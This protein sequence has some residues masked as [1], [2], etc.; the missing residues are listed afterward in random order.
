MST[1]TLTSLAILKV[2]L[3]EGRDYL[4]YLRPF[5]LQVLVDHKPA[6]ITDRVVTSYI[7]KQFGLDIPERAVEIV[8][9]RISKSGLLKKEHGKYWINGDL[10][11]PQI[12]TK[13]SEANRHIDAI[14]QGLQQFSKDTAKAISDP[15]KAVFAI[16]AF[17]AEFDITCLRAYLRGTAIPQLEESHQ[18]DIVLVSKYIQYLQQTDPERFSSFL[19]LVQGHML[20]N[21]LLCPDLENAPQTYNAVTF[22]F[23]TPLLIHRL[24]LEGKAKKDAMCELLDL[25]SQLGG[26]VSVFSHSRE[27]LQTVLDGVANYVDSPDG[28][29]P[30][31][32]EAKKRGT[33]KSDLL[34]IAG[35]IDDRLRE[36]GIDVE[37]T[38]H[39]IKAFQID[40]TVFGD[41]LGDEIWYRNPRAAQ[42]DTNS[43]RSIYALRSNKLALSIEKAR[44][45]LVTSN[46]KFAKAA[47]EYGQQHESSKDVSSVITSF[48]LANMA[49]L[50]APV[51]NPKIPTTQL[52]AFSYAALEPS[53]ELLSKY[54]KEIDKLEDQGTINERDHQL[55]RSS[56]AYDELMDLTLGEDSALTEKTIEQTLEHVV[57]E[58]EKEESEKLT[59]ERREHQRT[60]DELNSQHEH[61][62]NE[63]K[64]EESEKLTKERREHQRTQDE[65]N[66]QQAYNQKIACNL[67]R[68][69]HGMAR[70]F[71]W[72]LSGGV[73]VLLTIGLLPGLGL[74]PTAPV[75]LIGSSIILA[76]LTLANLVL[77][78]TVKNLHKWFQ[79]RC[80]NWLLKLSSR[81]FG[82]DLGKFMR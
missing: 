75:V 22:Y 57:N 46:N 29:G 34:L 41:I 69:C 15:D 27:E 64:K 32:D 67:Y 70:A 1:A 56:P 58:I 81:A 36:A 45:V 76:L 53:A 14:V 54:L 33:T 60:Q 80:L 11:D 51:R 63:I 42:Y 59:K 25:L 24:G 21:A 10:P 61:V 31:V 39:Y 73:A 78:I 20:A 49:W 18:I 68:L 4:E 40:E 2:N 48:S 23:D 65:L 62:V 38:P 17:L 5:I 72:G 66:S 71:V 12:T 37:D 74:R 44:A 3:D 82:V 8:L 79:D 28:R 77:G 7:F 55:L 6:P 52:L 13:K 30:I 50:K 19:V 26:K 9:K 16:C 43:V 35:S 47:W